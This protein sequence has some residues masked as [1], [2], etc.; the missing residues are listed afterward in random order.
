[1][2]IV[3]AV[4][5]IHIKIFISAYQATVMQSICTLF[6]DSLKKY[7]QGIDGGSKAQTNGIKRLP[8]IQH[9][10]KITA[11]GLVYLVY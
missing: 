1:M 6:G 4:V 2:C 10:R 8:S 11:L 3:T 9:S 7:I 5:E